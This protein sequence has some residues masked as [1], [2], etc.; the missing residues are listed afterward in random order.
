M[1]AWRTSAEAPERRPR[2]L[3]WK[4]PP[5]A[6]APSWTARLLWLGL[7]ASASILLL[8]V[9][10][11]LTQDVAAIPFLWII[12]LVVYLLSFIICFESPRLYHRAVFVPL[13]IASLGFMAYRLWPD[14]SNSTCAW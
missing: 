5:T 12:P 6:V 14:H 13:L 11:H 4:T 1:T 2:Q 9:T 8:A 7:S 10:T 3:L